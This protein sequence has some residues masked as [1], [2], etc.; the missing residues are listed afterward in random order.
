MN[1]EIKLIAI[2]F[3]NYVKFMQNYIN[4]NIFFI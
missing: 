4:R 1:L 2:A 3:I